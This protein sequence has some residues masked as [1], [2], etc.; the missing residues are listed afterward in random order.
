MHTTLQLILT[1]LQIGSVYILFSL[2]LTLIFGVMKVVNFAHGQFFTL[3]ALLVSVLVPSFTTWGL[4]LAAAFLA[5]AAVAIGATAALGLLVY[6]FGFR[7]FQRDLVGSFILSAGLVLLF[8]GAFLHFFGGAVRAVPP[9]IEGMVS[10]FGVNIMAQRLVLCIVALF[11]TVVLYFVLTATRLGK[12]MRAVS[13]DHEAAMLQGIPYRKIALYGFLIATLLGAL[14]GAIVA[15]VS[16][17]TPTV[18]AD[19]LV[20]GFIAVIIGGLGSV[21]GAIFGSLFIAFIESFGGHFF[22]PSTASLAIF[23]LVMVTLL[24]RPKGLLGNG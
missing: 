12:A 22:D 10:I 21:P 8:E 9:I 7:F 23:V 24:V 20:K 14:A 5:S 6:Q 15:P 18:G 13:I 3:A 11:F 16:V 4:S 1:G 17:V 19:Y 2:G